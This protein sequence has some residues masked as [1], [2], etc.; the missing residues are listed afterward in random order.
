MPYPGLTIAEVL[1]GGTYGQ[2][3]F[4]GSTGTGENNS[5]FQI[6]LPAGNYRITP[7]YLEG[8]VV[9]PSFVQAISEGTGTIT[10]YYYSNSGL[11]SVYFRD[12]SNENYPLGY[13]EIPVA[14]VSIHEG[15]SENVGAFIHTYC[16]D[17]DL[18][19]DGAFA[20]SGPVLPI[21]SYVAIANGVSCYIAPA[22]L[23]FA[24]PGSTFTINVD[25]ERI[26]TGGP[27]L[28]SEGGSLVLTAGGR[29]SLNFNWDLDNNG[30]YEWTG[31]TLNVTSSAIGGPGE[32]TIKLLVCNEYPVCSSAT[33]TVSIEAASNTPVD[34]G[35]VTV[36]GLGNGNV[37]VTFPAVYAAGTTTAELLDNP[38][39]LAQLPDGYSGLTALFYNISTT[40]SVEFP[41]TVC[42]T[43]DPSRFVDPSAVRLF[44]EEAGAW[45][46]I[47]GEDYPQGNTICGV[48]NSLS[49]FGAFEA[50]QFGDLTFHFE[51]GLQNRIIGL[52]G[53]L[54]VTG[55]SGS[56]PGIVDSAGSV[57]FA[58]LPIGLYSIENLTA[59]D[60]Y[61]DPSIAP[62]SATVEPETENEFTYVFAPL[63]VSADAGGPYMLYDDSSIE[64]VASGTGGSTL[65]Y[66]WDLDYDGTF[67]QTGVRQTISSDD[68]DSHGE[69]E[70]SVQV[71]NVLNTCA[72]D[73][74]TV[75]YA[76]MPLGSPNGAAVIVF[77]QLA[78][79]SPVL[80]ACFRLIGEGDEFPQDPYWEW[81]STFEQ[82]E[83]DA[84]SSEM[85]GATVFAGPISPGTYTLTTDSGGAVL[86]G[87]SE[88]ITIGPDD[89]ELE[90]P[91]VWPS[92]PAMVITLE[93]GDGT[94]LDGFCASYNGHTA[95][96]YQ[97][98]GDYELELYLHSAGPIDLTYVSK[99]GQWELDFEPETLSWDGSTTITRNYVATSTGAISLVLNVVDLSG[100]PVT[101]GGFSMRTSAGVYVDSSQDYVDGT[102]GVHRFTYFK[103]QE[104]TTVT[105]SHSSPITGFEYAESF[106][107]GIEPGEVVTRTVVLEPLD[108]LAIV[109]VV[110]SNG[111]LV[112]GACF[113]IRNQAN[114]SQYAM[115]LLICDGQW[116]RDQDGVLTI[117]NRWAPND[118]DPGTYLL[119]PEVNLLV[120]PS[121]PAQEFTWEDGGE[122]QTL[123]FT[124]PDDALN[125][126]FVDQNGTKASGGCVTLT[127]WSGEF[128]YL[129]SRCDA[130]D[131]RLDGIITYLQMPSGSYSVVETTAPTGLGRAATKQFYLGTN[132]PQ[133]ITIDHTGE[134]ANT[135]VGDDIEVENLASGSVS[136]TFESVTKAGLTTASVYGDPSSLAPLPGGYA[137]SNALFFDIATDADFS[138]SVTVCITFPVE[139][140]VDPSAVRLL[141]EADGDW[142]DITTGGDP[143][144]GSICG[145]TYSLSPFALAESSAMDTPAGD[146]VELSFFGDEVI[147]SLYS[148]SEGGTTKL[149][150]IADPVSFAAFGY[151]DASYR[152]GS[153]RGF[154]VETTA[155]VGYA[156]VCVAYDPTGSDAGGSIAA[157]DLYWAETGTWEWYNN[158]H[159]GSYV[160]ES[161]NALSPEATASVLYLETTSPTVGGG[162][163]SFVDA[164]T[165][166]PIQGTPDGAGCFD[167][168]RLGTTDPTYQ[169]C[170]ATD[171]AG[172][173]GTIELVSP[174]LSPAQ[175]EVV[176]YSPPS[177]YV[178]GEDL[179]FTYLSCRGC[180]S[181]SLGGVRLYQVN[182]EVG[183]DVAVEAT[184]GDGITVVFAEVNEPGATWAARNFRGGMIGTP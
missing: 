53:G 19:I 16:D 21:G 108:K 123:V 52:G 87:W 134:L 159:T 111:N 183:F 141:H 136:M 55:S 156:Q 92:V 23:D 45:V 174:Q 135:P 27:Y 32:H 2:P 106:S 166:Q 65:T 126:A 165:L 127:A 93:T 176:S 64:L 83:C 39:G 124:V 100:N 84:S 15:T 122:P 28:V 8:H 170:D 68:F 11:P 113:S 60:A 50:E 95:C 104:P 5:I 143:A 120:T 140:F 147:L 20:A 132:R 44:H 6:T 152:S 3:Y 164:Q 78:D 172:L 149:S 96:E 24:N 168:A 62:I 10:L 14:C 70:V 79:G 99:W 49:P 17:A 97:D 171:S 180:G 81:P 175:W 29:S 151:G 76:A 36:F 80:D 133:T 117:F 103:P 9:P 182:T 112:S 59:P 167:V 154:T 54:T 82:A 155:T 145:L 34:T 131:G 1:D 148:I 146:E 109:R 142:T 162:E 26:D 105:I 38:V 116:D 177:G 98:R 73:S 125:I 58:G 75:S 110:D 74:S 115:S 88:Q 107:I 18:F 12:T 22:P 41:A 37:E 139:N 63:E 184:G 160:C 13:P 31:N 89:A 179:Y 157:L 91:V 4:Y 119:M 67:D 153:L 102:D 118:L 85:D 138:G 57:S 43:F 144:N 161:L 56:Y 42:I 69:Y 47:T 163:I 101:G 33:T 40:A 51:D 130:F 94:R 77:A 7:Q 114:P 169:L 181:S 72:I 178:M 35:P 66:S 137:T 121:G 128:I 158:V 25:Y 90:I 129:P 86:P 30:S 48:T 150:R 173:D 61:G 71:C 46:D